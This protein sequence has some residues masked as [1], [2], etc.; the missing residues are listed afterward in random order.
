MQF[1]ALFICWY[2]PLISGTKGTTTETDPARR[3]LEP[4]KLDG[5]RRDLRKN[6]AY[7][8]IARDFGKMEKNNS[9]EVFT[10]KQ[11]SAEIKN[12]F[13]SRGSGPGQ[14]IAPQGVAVDVS[15][16]IFVTDSGNNRICVYNS[17][18]ERMTRSWGSSGRARGQFK[19]PNAI[20]VTDEKAV[21]VTDQGNARIQVFDEYGKLIHKWGGSK[22]KKPASEEEE[23]GSGEEVEY[24]WRGM[25]DPC[26]LSI[27]Q[28]GRIAV[29]DCTNNALFIY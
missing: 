17:T 10:L 22:Q 1:L 19:N 13:G 29:S 2:L 28:A 14:M 11:E 26:G 9:I 16:N 5:A 21:F 3:R 18:G 4:A 27:S 20:Y 7:E 24:I 8:V 12:V 15:G 6:Q 25:K 23:G